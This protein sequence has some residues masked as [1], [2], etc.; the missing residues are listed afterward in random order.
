MPVN[1]HRITCQKETFLFIQV[2]ENK[3]LVLHFQLSQ[4]RD[5]VE[6]IT[7]ENVEHLEKQRHLVE[8][9]CTEHEKE[10]E[11]QINTNKVVHGVPLRSSS[12][13]TNT[14][15]ER[16]NSLLRKECFFIDISSV[17]LGAANSV[18]FCDVIYIK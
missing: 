14:R 11:Q 5:L 6:K 1:R 4:Q 16:V 2:V 10:K 9:Y 3:Q 17:S 15:L 13:T 8:E 12:V 18:Y 7:A